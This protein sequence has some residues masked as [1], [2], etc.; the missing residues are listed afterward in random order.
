[1]Q[2]ITLT[3]KILILCLSMFCIIAK[4]DILKGQFQIHVFLFFTNLSILLCFLFYSIDMLLFVTQ[5]TVDAVLISAK[6]SI[7]LYVLVT[8][9]IYNVVLVPRHRNTGIQHVFYSP[10]D[11]IGHCFI[12][13]LVLFDWVFSTPKVNIS[14]FSPISWLVIPIFYCVL[15]LVKGKNHLGRKFEYLNSFYPYYFMDIDKIGSKKFFSN[16]VILIIV[17]LG[18]GYFVLFINYCR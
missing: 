1:M 9:I 14:F 11:L 16:I 7:V 17:F 6:G 2:I 8:M 5:Y 13:A 15:I 10:L 3:I 12:P 18:L 4:T